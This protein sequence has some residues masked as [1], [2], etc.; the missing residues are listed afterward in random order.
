MTIILV[1]MMILIVGF[2]LRIIIKGKLLE[3]KMY[4]D[5]RD[6][7]QYRIDM[8][9]RAAKATSDSERLRIIDELLT[10]ST[11]R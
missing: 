2:N 10:K 6:A 3:R 11:R 5:I 4:Q 9:C 1:I 8:K 7:Q